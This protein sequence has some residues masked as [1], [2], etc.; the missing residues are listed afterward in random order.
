MSFVNRL[1]FVS[2]PPITGYKLKQ[3]VTRRITTLQ[4]SKFENKKDLKLKN[5]TLDHSLKCTFFEIEI[6]ASPES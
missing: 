4:T 2:N 3:P 5:V 1:Q 6:Y